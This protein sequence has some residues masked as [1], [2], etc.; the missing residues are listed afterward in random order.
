MIIIIII[1]IIGIR[2]DRNLSN[3]LRGLIIKDL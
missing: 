3:R 2:Q 1:I